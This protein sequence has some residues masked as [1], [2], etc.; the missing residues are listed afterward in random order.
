[1]DRDS[2][3]GLR[4]QPGYVRFVSAATLARVSD[5][6]SFAM[7]A[8]LAGPVATGLGSA[9]AIVCAALAQIAAACVGLALMRL[10]AR[11]LAQPS[12]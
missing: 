5:V 3:R 2:L 6:G 11:A 12:G 8:A 9:D 4:A 1:V 7:G 10:P